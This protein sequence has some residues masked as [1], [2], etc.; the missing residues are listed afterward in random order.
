[1][2][3]WGRT[4]LSAE[5]STSVPMQF[6]AVELQ[7]GRTQLSA[8]ISTSVPMQFSAVELQW[9]RTQLSAEIVTLT[10][11][12]RATDEASMGPHSTECGNHV[13]SRAGGP[14]EGGF[15]GAALN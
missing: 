5:I 3:Q 1:M 11:T 9:G 7:W 6:S 15:N 4:Q 13:L 14:V 8:E 10:R 12:L 2:L